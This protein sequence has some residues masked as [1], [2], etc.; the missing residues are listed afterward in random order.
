MY[1][2]IFFKIYLFHL[3]IFGCAGSSLLRTVFLWLQQVGAA[4]R[5]S[6]HLLIAVVSLVVEHGL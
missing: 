6:V 3:F 4:L 5:C 2:Y 1:M